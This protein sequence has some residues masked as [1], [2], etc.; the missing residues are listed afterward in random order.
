MRTIVREMVAQSNLLLDDEERALEALGCEVLTEVPVP[1]R[2]NVL[3]EGYKK[4]NGSK[5][6]KSN[7]SNLEN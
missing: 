5:W 2:S 6:I 1:N 3:Q 4:E 7:T